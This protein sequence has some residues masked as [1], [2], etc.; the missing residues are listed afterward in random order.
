MCD[1]AAKRTDRTRSHSHLIPVLYD[2]AM[3]RYIVYF[4]LIGLMYVAA[5][6]SSVDS[7]VDAS[8]PPAADAVS[9]NPPDA[10]NDFCPGEF[11]FTGEY[12]DWDSTDDAFL[13]VG[14]NQS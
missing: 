4:A 8:N 10:N 11:L 12:V 2:T 6:C 13:G 5:G 7:D 14:N 3:E 1:L 9:T